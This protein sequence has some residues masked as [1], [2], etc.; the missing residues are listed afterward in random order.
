MLFRFL[1][2]LSELAYRHASLR[3][4]L[5]LLAIAAL[6]NLLVFPAFICQIVPE[7]GP[8]ILDM[9]FGYSPLEAHEALTAFGPAGRQAYLRMLWLA[10][11]PYPLIY[12]LLLVLSASFFLDR[13]LRPGSPFRLFNL[14][15]IDAVIFD[16]IE[17][18]GITGLLL[19]Y[20][21][22]PDS[23][24]RLASVAGILKWLAI[25]VSLIFIVIGI[26]GW[27]FHSRNDSLTP[28]EK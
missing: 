28:E 16:L 5:P 13:G 17:N 2:R 26:V 15:A 6:F 21:D 18:M 25:A 4:I 1:E 11:S 12:G 20:P 7:G 14:A 9:R 22:G 10:D 3:H 24:A 27:L 23:L 8:A 19:R